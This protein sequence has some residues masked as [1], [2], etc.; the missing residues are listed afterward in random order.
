MLLRCVAAEP[1]GRVP[2]RHPSWRPAPTLDCRLSAIVYPLHACFT[3][4]TN[5]LLR[6]FTRCGACT[7]VLSANGARPA[8]PAWFRPVLP[9]VGHAD[10]GSPTSPG[11]RIIFVPCCVQRHSLRPSGD[12]GPG[13]PC[14]APAGIGMPQVPRRP[15]ANTT[16]PLTAPAKPQQRPLGCACPCKNAASKLGVRQLDA[17]LPPWCARTVGCGSACVPQVR[18]HMS[19]KLST[20]SLPPAHVPEGCA[21]LHRSRPAATYAAA[22]SLRACH[23][24]RS[25]RPTSR[26]PLPRHGRPR[27]HADILGPHPTRADPGPRLAQ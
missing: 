2:R 24:M 7:C 8:P 21:S 1:T 17:L 26:L 10:P 15:A 25:A 22:F 20:T 16:F 4:S 19:R 27:G 3:A 9:C 18:S 6:V 11:T 5:L 12:S 23:A 13:R 14:L